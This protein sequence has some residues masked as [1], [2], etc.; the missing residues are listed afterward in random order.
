MTHEQRRSLASIRI[1]DHTET[2]R[3]LSPI[4]RVETLMGSGKVVPVPTSH[5][6]ER[7]DRHTR[8]R[9]EADTAIHP[10]IVAPPNPLV[11]GPTT[12][13]ASTLPQ[14]R[15][16][17][18]SD[19]NDPATGSQRITHDAVDSFLDDGT[20]PDDGTPPR[21]RARRGTRRRHRRLRSITT[22]ARPTF[23]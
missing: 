23:R 2:R 3:E 10:M 13:A 22:V 4:D 9:D 17:Q 20:A 19:C 18:S 8:H 1:L 16:L 7:G 15:T 5:A 6:S 11:Q 21:R 12:S 14:H